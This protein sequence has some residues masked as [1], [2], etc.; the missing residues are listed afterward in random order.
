MVFKVIINLFLVI[1]MAIGRKATFALMSPKLVIP[2][3]LALNS[4]SNHSQKTAQTI[5]FPHMADAVADASSFPI[6]PE[7][8]G[9]LYPIF[10]TFY[11]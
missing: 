11:H 10:P 9:S 6:N 7:S 2:I 4:S 1:P 3:H 5:A 8:P